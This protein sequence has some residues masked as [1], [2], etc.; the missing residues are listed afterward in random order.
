MSFV[1]VA[2]FEASWEFWATIVA[3]SMFSIFF[4]EIKTVRIGLLNAVSGFVVAILFHNPV[5]AWLRW[6]NETYK[7]AALFTLAAAGSDIIRMVLNAL[8][9]PIEYLRALMGKG[10][11]D[12]R[13]K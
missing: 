4:A 12:D 3:G 5:L 1:G 6:D 7:L 10:K 9:H 11:S 13:D 2:M 8:R